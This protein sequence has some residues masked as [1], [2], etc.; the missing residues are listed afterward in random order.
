[1]KK[2]DVLLN[3]VFLTAAFFL[4]T[5]GIF[6]LSIRADS[7]GLFNLLTHPWMAIGKNFFLP[8]AFFSIFISFGILG[9]ATLLT[10]PGLARFLGLQL[11]LFL[12][13]IIAIL[14]LTTWLDGRIFEGLRGFIPSIADFFQF[15]KEGSSS[16][17]LSLGI[18]LLLIG[19]GY[20]SY[21]FKNFSGMGQPLGNAR[22]SHGWDLYRA[23]FFSKTG[24]VLAKSFYGKL[25]YSGFEP[26]IVV[27]G[28]GGGKT[29]AVVIPN[30]FELIHENIVVT[31]IKG[32]VYQKTHQYRESLGQKVFRFE[33]ASNTTHRYNPLGLVRESHLDEDLDMIFKTLIPDSNDPLWADGSRNVAKMLA[34]FEILEQKKTPSL[35]GIYQTICDP[36]FPEKIPLMVDEIKTQRVSNLFGKFLSARD[37]TQKDLLLNAQ[38]Y[39]SKFDSPNLAYATSGNDFDFRDLRKILMTIYLIMPSNTET[40]GPIAAIFFEQMIRLTTEKNEPGK[41]EYS[42]NAFIDEFG[43]LPKMPSIAKGIS[44][45][46]SYR[47][48]VCAFVQHI[49]QLKAV[50][51]E[52]SKEGFLASPVKLAF[53]ITSKQDADYFSALAGKKTITLKNESFRGDLSLN[54][55]AQK[56][57]RDLIQPDEIMR[58][59]R[60][61]LLIYR[62][63]FQV[64]RGR[65]NFPK[66][67]DSTHK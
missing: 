41:E 32:E 56:Q 53:N 39:L 2:A 36:N 19:V 10:K 51:G 59:S 1:M 11:A 25:R 8:Q 37:K 52:E 54:I 49:A 4:L 55:S 26:I 33:P 38:E 34:M 40:F 42:I 64:V 18:S 24:I 12:A 60:S 15:W 62:S 45:L 21:L 13:V 27:S 35:Q 50:Y 3:S 67:L 23:G 6:E 43:N 66:S 30:M 14:G 5:G 48:R 58:M 46:R 29:K 22:F 20:L 47:I 16:F 31:D 63:G 65:K 57:M 17:W 7:F 61:K 28:T 44:F 9:A